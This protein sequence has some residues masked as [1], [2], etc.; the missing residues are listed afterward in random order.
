MLPVIP[1]ALTVYYPTIISNATVPYPYTSQVY[2]IFEQGGPNQFR[3]ANINFSVDNTIEMKLKPKST[4]TSGKERK[5]SLLDGLTFS[6]AYNIAA[7]SFKLAPISVSGH[8]ALFNQK[9][10]VSFSGTFDP[11]L[12]N[13]R[14][15]ITN[16][17]V[18]K[19]AQRINRFSFQDGKFPALTNFNFSLSG[20]LNPASFKPPSNVTA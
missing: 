7:D 12:T 9:V 3:Q 18:I 16:N 11:Y 15:T 2:S 20:S 17:Q 5:I 19:Y 10:N 14:D 4:D 13:V 8:T 1:A 6:T